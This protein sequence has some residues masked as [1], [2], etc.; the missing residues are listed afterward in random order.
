MNKRILPALGAFLSLFII[1]LVGV[2]F[3]YGPIAAEAAPGTPLVPA[4]VALL[5]STILFVA[6]FVW[7]AGEMGNPLKAALAVAL[8]QFLLVDVDYVLTGRRG[9]VEAA[10][11]AVLL[12]VAWAI[13]GWVYGKLDGRM[14]S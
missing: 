14:P 7:I 12:L 9:L 11:S 2:I 8:S 4:F 10:A 5:V 3:F 13:T 6:L 1:Y